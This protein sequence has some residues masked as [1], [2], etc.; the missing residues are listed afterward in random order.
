MIS[1]V[2]CS[3]DRVNVHCTIRSYGPVMMF[4]YMADCFCFSVCLHVLRK[5]SAT[6][7][8]LDVRRLFGTVL[9][10]G[11]WTL[12]YY[13]QRLSWAAHLWL[14]QA[15]P[16]TLCLV[17]CGLRSLACVY[18]GHAMPHVSACVSAISARRT[19]PFGTRPRQMDLELTH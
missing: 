17:I 2:R 7:T 10:S 3:P 9:S 4:T 1:D 18:R 19:E 13:A 12:G 14:R 11:P 15:L 8:P 5:L 6:G 16:M